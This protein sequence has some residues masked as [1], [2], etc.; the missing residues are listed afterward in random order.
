L[1]LPQQGTNW[2]LLCRDRFIIAVFL[3]PLVESWLRGSGLVVREYARQM[4]VHPHQV[5]R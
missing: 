4:A 3:S 1:K 2:F 5:S